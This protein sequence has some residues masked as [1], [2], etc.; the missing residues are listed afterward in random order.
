[1]SDERAHRRGVERGSAESNNSAA[2]A[3]GTV[4][5]LLRPGS[6]R[7]TAANAIVPPR[8]SRGDARA[9]RGLLAKTKDRCQGA[10]ISLCFGV[11]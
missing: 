1:M 5:I 11:K 10:L 4:H 2:R 3:I 7:P 6:G 8:G 9:A